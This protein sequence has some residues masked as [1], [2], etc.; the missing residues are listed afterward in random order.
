MSRSIF[1]FVN[2]GILIVVQTIYKDEDLDIKIR[3]GTAI[4]FVIIMLVMTYFSVKDVNNIHKI[5]N[6]LGYKFD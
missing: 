5:K 4:I 6:E 1:I 3:Y 2:L